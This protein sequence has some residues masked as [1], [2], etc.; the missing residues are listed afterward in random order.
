M[1]EAQKVAMI[2]GLVEASDLSAKE[3]LEAVQQV[4]VWRGTSEAPAAKVEEAS[5]PDHSGQRAYAGKETTRS[6]ILN[7]LED[8]PEGHEGLT[9]SDLEAQLGCS[10]QILLTALKDLEGDGHILVFGEG[11]IN[12]PYRYLRKKS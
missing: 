11:K 3:K 5:A 7:A 2:R 9:R 6:R 10:K 1:R 12:R 4:L 8:L